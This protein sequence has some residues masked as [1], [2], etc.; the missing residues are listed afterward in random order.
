MMRNSSI[1]KKANTERQT[2]FR[3]SKLF[4]GITHQFRE[5]LFIVVLFL[6]WLHIFSDLS[7]Y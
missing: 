3:C 7:Q 5:N 1:Q 6:Y 2:A 4:Y